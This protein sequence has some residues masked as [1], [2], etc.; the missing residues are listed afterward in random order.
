VTV[1]RA[2]PQP[3]SVATVTTALPVGSA[4]GDLAVF[5]AA[6]PSAS[7][8]TG[9][10]GPNG[11]WA[12]Q[13][14]AGGVDVGGALSRMAVYTKILDQADL[15][16]T[17]VAVS[18][19]TSNAPWDIAIASFPG[20]TGVNA[21]SAS[22]SYSATQVLP[23]PAVTPLVD[24]S[25][26]VGCGVG[27]ATTATLQPKHT[28][29]SGWTFG[30]EAVNATG[31]AL[32]R[33]AWIDYLQLVL[34]AGSPVS[35]SAALQVPGNGGLLTLALTPAAA[36]SA[37]LLRPT[38]ELVAVAWLKA[39]VPYLG[40]RV[41]TE[42]PQ[43]NSTWSASGFTQVSVAGGSPNIYLPVSRPVVSVD[44]YGVAANGG[45]PPWNLAAQQAEQI[46]AAA[47]AHG[48][49]PRWV[50]LPGAYAP[51]RVLGV[52]PRT[53]PRRVPGDAASYAR[54]QMDLEIWWAT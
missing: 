53:E 48:T 22:A 44:T 11:A 31:P 10:S 23:Y 24:G 30:V 7:A 29:P 6:G 9:P 2:F 26:I 16:Q 27:R 54:F 5:V 35:A 13:T 43:D 42:L 37:A 40:S 38:A 18:R 8:F 15:D 32:L 39:A 33:S 21:V 50:T 46:K 20:F 52:I 47:L 19:P 1:T 28:Q 25:L 3:N 49:V 17:I 4:V 34:G 51:V 41:A 14:P 36:P 12:E 45:R